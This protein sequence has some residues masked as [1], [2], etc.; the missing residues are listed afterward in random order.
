[1]VSV[2]AGL[3]SAACTSTNPA[4]PSPSADL[5]ADAALT[6]SIIAPRP[7]SPA[8]GSA[9]QF[10]AQPVTLTVLNAIVTR[11]TDLTYT[12]EVAT[13]AAF[14]TKVQTKDG[15]AQGANGQTSVRLDQLAASRDYY[16]HARAAGG[17]TTGAFGSAYKFTVGA[18]I[19]VNAPSPISPLTNSTT[20]PRPTLRVTNATR[21]G[22]TG[23]ITYRFEI[24]NSSAFSGIIASTTVSEGINETGFTPTGDLPNN[25]LLFWRAVAIDATNNITSGASSVQSFTTKSFSQA[26]A[27]AAQLGQP[28]WPGQ[29]P[30]GTVGH[31]TMG[32]EWSLGTRYYAPGNVFFQ[33]PD[34]EMARIFDLLDRGMAPDDV[35]GWLNSHGYPSQVLWYPPPEKGVLGLQYVYIASRNKVTVN[36]I[37]DVVTRVE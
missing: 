25:Q 28:L 21:S 7:Q 12:F 35:S 22:P 29:Q 23:A 26:E 2:A 34:I 10:A 36:G 1:M 32:N 6:A 18:A 5:V 4:Q 24:A 30:T 8:N 17:G 9:V 33:S 16:W 19:T 31:A 15:V 20:S 3:A 37:W 27:L 13:D 14:A 11:P